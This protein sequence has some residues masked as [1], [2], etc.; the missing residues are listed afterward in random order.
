MSI[1][2]SPL[3]FMLTVNKL[4][5]KQ[6]RS[7]Y[8]IIINNKFVNV[9]YYY[10]QRALSILYKRYKKPIIYYFYVLQ[11]TNLAEIKIG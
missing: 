11:K 7:D 5:I 4:E 9:K 2:T 6:V 3:F 1:S 8:F 10:Y